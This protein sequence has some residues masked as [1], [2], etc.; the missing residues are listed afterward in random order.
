MY[1]DS[2][3]HL[4]LTPLCDAEGEVVRRAREAGVSRIVTIGIDPDSSERAI[5]IAHRHA[6]V[7]AAVGLHPHD[8]SS[9]SED[10]LARLEELSRCDKVVGIGETG[11]DFYRDRSPRDAQ[12]AAFREQIRLA[13]RRSLPVVVHDREAHGEILSILAQENAAEVG[14]II[15]CFSGDYE[16]ARR[17]IGMNFLVSIPGA[18]TY[19][20]S[21]TQAE[22]VGKIPLEKLLIETDCPFLAP[23]PYRGKPNEPAYVPLVARKIAEIKGVSAEDVGRVTALN[24]LRIFR[25]PSE[26]EVRVSYKIRNSLYLNITNRC[27]NACTFCAK[28]DDYHVKGHYLK[29]PGEPSVEEILAEVGDPTQYDEIVFCGFGEP[30][31]RLGDVMTIAKSL[32]AKGAKIRV[33]TDGLANLVHGRNV[34][35]ELSGLVDALSVSLNAPDAETYARLCPNRYGAASFPALLDFLREA[36]RHVPS[37]T[38][39]AVALP[40]LDPDAVRRLAETIDGVAFRLRPFAEVG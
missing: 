5:A 1:F 3:A 31:L 9:R 33:N 27:T 20:G 10:L 19:K 17:A 34:L 37:V 7:Y 12:R 26:E 30:L 11:L 23:L 13:R 15:H 16:M 35:P 8:A 28:R 36:P 21:Q 18:I 4:D 25:I 40:G 38:A 24:A 29:L 39:T 22:A 6:G 14:G 2:H 32:K